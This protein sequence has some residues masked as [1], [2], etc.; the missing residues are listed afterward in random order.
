MSYAARVRHVQ[1][2]VQ[3]LNGSHERKLDFEYILKVM[4]LDSE[5]EC[6]SWYNSPD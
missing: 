4:C 3:Y 2:M 1:I 6:E 5:E